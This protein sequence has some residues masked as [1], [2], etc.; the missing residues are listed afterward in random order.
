MWASVIYG[1]SVGSND[2]VLVAA[3]QIGNVGGQPYWSWYGF[4]SRVD[5]GVL[6]LF[7]GVPM[8]VATLKQ[9]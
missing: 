8:N 7:H 5:N 3:S 4:D 1:S 6:V 2:I 9:D